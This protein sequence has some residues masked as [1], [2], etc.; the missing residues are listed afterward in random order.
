MVACVSCRL[1][2]IIG[3]ERNTRDAMVGQGEGD[4]MLRKQ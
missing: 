2:S 3:G 4:A 1:E